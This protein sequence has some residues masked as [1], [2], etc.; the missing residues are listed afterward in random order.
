ML[1]G[2]DIHEWDPARDSQLPSPFGADD[3]SAQ[4]C[5]A[6]ETAVDAALDYVERHAAVVR[7]GGG[8]AERV[9]G[10]GF[11]HHNGRPQ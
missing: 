6:H 11:A 5:G 8:G 1:N 2:I 4:I 3:L 10:N 7:R 9:S